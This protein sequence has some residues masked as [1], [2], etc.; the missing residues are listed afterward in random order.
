MLVQMPDTDAVVKAVLEEGHV[1][2]MSTSAKNLAAVTRSLS[3]T[4]AELQFVLS[5]TVQIC[6][7]ELIRLV[8]QLNFRGMKHAWSM[9][10]N[11]ITSC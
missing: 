10:N 4:E 3:A 2:N 7:I 6:D 9:H 1:S 11:I 5:N 8:E